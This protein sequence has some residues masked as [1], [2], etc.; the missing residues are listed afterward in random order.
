MAHYRL[1]IRNS[2]SGAL[3]GQVEFDEQVQ[4]E[5]LAKSYRKLM[6]AVADV[7]DGEYAAQLMRKRFLKGQWETMSA[8]VISCQVKDGK[9]ALTVRRVA[10]NRERQLLRWLSE[11]DAD[12]GQVH[13]TYSNGASVYDPIEPV[14]LIPAFS[15]LHYILDALYYDYMADCLPADLYNK[16]KAELFQAD[17]AIVDA[18]NAHGLTPA[19]SVYVAALAEQAKRVQEAI[20]AVTANTRTTSD[21]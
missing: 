19:N 5:A 6:D 16:V 13:E 14:Q 18:F 21:K 8:P 12:F 4:E 17:H 2:M 15:D 3:M 9:A 1:D 20:R 10:Y 7:A 11:L